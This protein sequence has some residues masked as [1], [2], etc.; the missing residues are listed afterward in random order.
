MGE[1]EV[2][3]AFGAGETMSTKAPKSNTEGADWR[4]RPLDDELGEAL[5]AGLL[6]WPG[7]QVKFGLPVVSS[8]SGELQKRYVL[9]E[10]S[11]HEERRRKRPGSPRMLLKMTRRG[12]P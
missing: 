11:R 10:A 2:G 1:G 4:T 12:Q 5:R 9:V 3:V 6:G 7:H 8:P